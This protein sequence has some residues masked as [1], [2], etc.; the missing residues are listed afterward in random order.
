MFDGKVENRSKPKDLSGVDLLQQLNCL[1]ENDFGKHPNKMK[2][3]RNPEELN[4]TKKSIFFELP[5]WKTMKLRHNLDVMHIEKNI[6]DNILGTMLN[7]EGKTKDT[8]TA[9]LDLEDMKIKKEL[10]LKKRED[11]SYLMPHACYTL[12]KEERK[13]FCCFLKKHKMEIQ[14]QSSLSVE[15]RHRTQFPLWFKNYVTNQGSKGISHEILSLAY[16]PDIRAQKY[17][18]CIVNGVRFHTKAR[19]KH[20]TSQN[21]GVTVEG[22]LEEDQINFYGILTDIIQLNY[23]KDYKVVLF[24]CK[25]FDLD[26]KKRRIHRDGHLLSINISKYWYESDPFILSVQAKQV[27]YL[28]DTKLG[29]DW[30]VVQKFHHR[31]LFDVP[32]MQGVENDDVSDADEDFEI[33]D[34]NMEMQISENISLHRNDIVA[35]VIDRDIVDNVNILVNSDQESEDGDEG[36]EIE[37]DEYDTDIEPAL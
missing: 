30:K 19:D 36:D 12:S 8:V 20:L 28:D 33:Y 9:R 29:K 4:W 32:E 14:L 37:S 11:G 24:K 16:G 2:R 22:N 27:F 1:N 3:K 6:C 31:H 10:Q 23:I 5:Y 17:M 18:G 26:N 15:E 7:I 13:K 35:N 34:R 25:W 21:S